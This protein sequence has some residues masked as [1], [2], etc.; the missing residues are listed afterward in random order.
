[1]REATVTTP[2]LGVRAIRDKSCSNL[3][4]VTRPSARSEG[5]VSAVA[6][7]FTVRLL[8]HSCPLEVS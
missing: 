6:Q 1:M 8:C 3:G 2:T 4:F 5:N 7:R